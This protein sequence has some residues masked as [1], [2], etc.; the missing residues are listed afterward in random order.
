MKKW[1]TWPNYSIVGAKGSLLRKYK[2][3]YRITYNWSACQIFRL[4]KAREGKWSNL[5]QT[6]SETVLEEKVR[7]TKICVYVMY[8]KRKKKWK[9]GT[10]GITFSVV[11]FF[12]FSSCLITIS[13]HLP[14]YR[15]GVES[16]KIPW[17]RG[18]FSFEGTVFY[19]SST[20]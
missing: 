14:P 11:F 3:V 20:F 8:L 13:V 4:K 12:S 7:P 10:K 16:Y 1:E 9:L 19:L 17:P 2:I 18:N 15:A 6:W 5:F